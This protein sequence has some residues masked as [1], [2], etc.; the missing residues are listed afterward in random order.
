VATDLQDAHAGGIGT[1]TR[2]CRPKIRQGNFFVARAAG[3]NA[4]III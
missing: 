1:Q 3:Y 2:R 4:F